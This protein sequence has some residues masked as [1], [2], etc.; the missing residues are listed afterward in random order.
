MGSKPKQQEYQPSETEKT[1]AAI[2]KAD[3][4]YF[5][6]TY[7][8]L[9]LEMRGTEPQPLTW[10]LLAKPCSCPVARQVTATRAAPRSRAH[11]WRVRLPWCTVHPVQT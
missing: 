3:A 8:P 11:V 10:G 6:R 1:Q 4:D 7:D 9:L 5:A 2:A